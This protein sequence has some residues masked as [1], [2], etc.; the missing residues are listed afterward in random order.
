[1]PKLE[2]AGAAGFA[3]GKAQRATALLESSPVISRP[4]VTETIGTLTHK[5]G[6]TLAEAL[7]D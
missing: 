2:L 4:L 3:P 1:M 5:Y 7:A 6:F